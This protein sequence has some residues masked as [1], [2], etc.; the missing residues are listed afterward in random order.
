MISGSCALLVLCSAIVLPSCRVDMFAI[1]FLRQRA[2]TLLFSH[3]NTSMSLLSSYFLVSTM[4]LLYYF[5]L[6]L[7][8]LFPGFD[9]SLMFLCSCCNAFAALTP[10]KN[11]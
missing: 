3:S 8:V 10:S 11:E 7:M 5:D 4:L 6:F 1:L 9:V 2:V